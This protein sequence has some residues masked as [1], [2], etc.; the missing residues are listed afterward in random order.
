MNY[1]I[2]YEAEMKLMHKLA[3][4]KEKIFDWLDVIVNETRHLEPLHVVH[5]LALHHQR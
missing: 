3:V 5:F 2:F 4:E 1:C